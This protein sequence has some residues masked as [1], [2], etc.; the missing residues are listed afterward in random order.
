M[1]Y[2]DL[3]HYWKAKGTC[4]LAPDHVLLAMGESDELIA[5]FQQAKS[6]GY[7]G[8][9][10]TNRKFLAV[11]YVPADVKNP[12][13]K[14]GLDHT[15]TIISVATPDYWG[16]AEHQPLSPWR[17]AQTGG[18]TYRSMDEFLTK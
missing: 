14:L 9:E 6:G 1:G 11:W 3:T 15:V 16:K 12:E 2:P 8:F 7:K 10:C 18:S 17:D 5:A 4:S 13:S